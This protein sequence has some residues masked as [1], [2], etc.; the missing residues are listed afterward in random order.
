MDAH[1]GTHA[2]T[3]PP[4]CARGRAGARRR[5]WRRRPGGQ[6][7]AGAGGAG[8]AGKTA[9]VSSGGPPAMPS[10]VLP[11]LRVPPRCALPER[12]SRGLGTPLSPSPPRPPFRRGP[13]RA[14]RGGREAAGRWEMGRSRD[15]FPLPPPA[16]AAL[17][18]Q[19][20]IGPPPPPPLVSPFTAPHR[21]RPRRPSRS[22]RRRLLATHAT[23]TVFPPYPSR[24]RPPR[25]R[26]PSSCLCTRSDHII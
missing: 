10:P 2:C 12:Q 26:L 24:A 1:A 14:A 22:R 9:M 4:T 23:H 8:A 7:T 20:A 6:Q 21:P 3:V 11:P 13:R 17:H 25:L 19:R 15:E 16:R 5:R 18:V